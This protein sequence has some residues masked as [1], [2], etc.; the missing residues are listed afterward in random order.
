MVTRVEGV[1]CV[2]VLLFYPFTV[3]PTKNDKGIFT[4]A[5]V[6]YTQ[7]VDGERFLKPAGSAG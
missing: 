1:Y 4:G 2:V 6:T 5:L 7:R 3:Y